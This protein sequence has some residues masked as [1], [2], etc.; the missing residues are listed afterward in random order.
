MR[1]DRQPRSCPCRDEGILAS[2]TPCLLLSTRLRFLW[3]RI[4]RTQQKILLLLPPRWRSHWKRALLPTRRGS[5]N[6]APAGA[7]DEDSAEETIAMMAASNDE[8]AD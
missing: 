6:E 8:E 5:S 2:V 3:T 1:D 7:E 4:L